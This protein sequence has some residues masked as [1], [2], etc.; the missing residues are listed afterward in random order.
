MTNYPEPSRMVRLNRRSQHV[1]L[2]LLPSGHIF[3]DDLRRAQKR[4]LGEDV[5]DIKSR[6][7]TSGLPRPGGIPRSFLSEGLKRRFPVP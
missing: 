4:K 3:A 7:L 1:V 2:N 5:Q 6:V